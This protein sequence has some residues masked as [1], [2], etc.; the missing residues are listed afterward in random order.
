MNTFFKTKFGFGTTVAIALALHAP[1]SYSQAVEIDFSRLDLTPGL[2]I[3]PL[4]ESSFTGSSADRVR[5][6]MAE[7]AQTGLQSAEPGEVPDL[8]LAARTVTPAGALAS[9]LDRRYHSLEEILPRLRYVPIAL[10]GTVRELSPMV[11]AT[12]AGGLSEG[13]WTGISRSWDVAGLGFIQLDESE[14]K[15]SGGSIT[16]VRE[17]LNSDVNG[18]PATVRTVRSADGAT[19]VSVSWVTETTTRRLNLQ[20]VDPAATKAN[21]QA[22]LSLARSLEAKRAAS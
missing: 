8:R 13:K 11:E 9:P 22:L 4:A 1:T 14:Y 19:L 16:L 2:H 3:V 6:E 10:T 15:D 17:L 5:A 7:R 12:T 20:P 21:E 18:H